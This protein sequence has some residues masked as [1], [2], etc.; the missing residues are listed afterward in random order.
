MLSSCCFFLPL[1]GNPVYGA[2]EAGDPRRHSPKMDV[3]SFGVMFVEMVVCELPDHLDELMRGTPLRDWPEGV[4]IVR[5]CIQRDP[6]LRPDMSEVLSQL[7][8]LRL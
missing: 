1:S 8:R 3:Y 7:G 6:Q 5:G 4:A 2:P